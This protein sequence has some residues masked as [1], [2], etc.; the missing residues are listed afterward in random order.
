MKR[1][2]NLRA[3]ILK[4]HKAKCTI[5]K[6]PDKK[7]IELD[8][9]HCI[10]H[11]HICQRYT[12]TPQTIR[13]HANAT[14]LIKKRDRKSFYW[15]L[16]ENAPMNKITMESSLEAAKQLDRIERVI[17]DNPTPSNIQVVYSF[18]SAKENKDA[19]SR[20]PENRDGVSAPADPVSLPPKRKEVSPI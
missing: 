20:A 5:C 18:A 11:S 6:H 1:E 10:P 9:I 19:N 7:E 17:V 4:Q 14:G 16:V 2:F 3:T 15:H 13:L 8:F 12:I